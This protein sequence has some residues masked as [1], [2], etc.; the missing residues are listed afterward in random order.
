MELPA[1]WAVVIVALAYG[2]F[3]YIVQSIMRKRGL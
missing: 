1:F 2:L 3:V